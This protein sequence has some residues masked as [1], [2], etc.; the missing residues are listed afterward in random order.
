M[1]TATAAPDGG[2]AHDL[3]GYQ[4]LDEIGRDGFAVIYRARQLRLQRVVT[5]RALKEGP[6]YAPD[7]YQKREAA[8]LAQLRHP[9]IV[10]LYDYLEH[11]GQSYLVLEYVDGG[12][13]ETRIAGH[14]QPVRPAVTLIERLAR[15]LAF[16]HQRGFV[17]CNL[18]PR[19]VLLA[20]PPDREPPGPV[21]ARDAEEVYGIPLVGGFDFAVD[22]HQADRLKEGE[23]RG[24]LAYMAPEQARGRHQ[25][26]GPATDLY[27]LGGILYEMLTGRTPFR[28]ATPLDTIRAV[29]ESEPEP[30]RR[31][32][33]G[34]DRKLETICLKCLRKDP[35]ARYSDGLELASDLR[36]YLS[37]LGRKRWF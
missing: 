19:N 31:L 22:R 25:D 21:E 4:I 9:H 33:P 5:L 15:T 36:G 12:T 20:V 14:R 29:L 2:D 18:K 10:S 16:V 13:L 23:I 37:G 34:V 28:G 6:G 24:T 1:S 30:P 17:H 7:E 11:E 32:N 27:A 26:L 8:I 3:P 35:A